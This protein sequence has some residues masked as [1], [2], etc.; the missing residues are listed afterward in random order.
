MRGSRACPI[1]WRG[2]GSAGWAHIVRMSLPCQRGG[3]P[4]PPLV[5]GG[6]SLPDQDPDS[7]SRFSPGRGWHRTGRFRSPLPWLI[8]GLLTFV[9][10]S[11]S[12]QTAPTTVRLPPVGPTS[13][14]VTVT[15]TLPIY[16]IPVRTPNATALE[17][18]A[19]AVVIGTPVSTATIEQTVTPG[20]TGTP[21]P[22]VTPIPAPTP[23]P[24][25]VVV[26]ATPVPTA[27][28]TPVPTATPM[29]TPTLTPTPTPTPGPVYG[30]EFA[31]KELARIQQFIPSYLL[32]GELTQL[33][34]DL[35]RV[36][37]KI[38]VTGVIK[39]LDVY[40]NDFAE[41]FWSDSFQGYSVRTFQG[42]PR[43]G[44]IVSAEQSTFCKLPP[45]PPHRLLPRFRRP[46]P[47]R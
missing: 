16:V 44:E 1:P 33:C 3:Q 27:T 32:V 45:L 35:I 2:R 38:N 6:V 40:I 13:T 25:I 43:P 18:T 14:M 10:L 34:T 31:D 9:S 11:C 12:A 23:T 24:V 8:L 47:C 42:L 15:P 26:T 5:M 4:L 28:P 36:I 7:R 22:T 30:Q 29:P 46:H 21:G 37:Q 39:P 41:I 19:E 17:P 20:D